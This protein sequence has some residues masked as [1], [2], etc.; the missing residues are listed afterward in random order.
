MVTVII[1]RAFETVYRKP[2]IDDTMLGISRRVINWLMSATITAQFVTDALVVTIWRQVK[3]RAL[4]HLSDRSSRYF[5]DQFH[6]LMAD[7]GVNCSMSRSDKC[8]E[9]AARESFLTWLKTERTARNM[10]SR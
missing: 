6:R 9:N 8:R 3:L 10:L 1:I 2:S 5:I 4:L 7:D